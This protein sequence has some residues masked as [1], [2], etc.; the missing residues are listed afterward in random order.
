[1]DENSHLKRARRVLPLKRRTATALSG[2]FT[3]AAG[4]A[5]AAGAFLWTPFSEGILYPSTNGPVRSAG[6]EDG[7]LNL[8]IFRH[9]PVFADEAEVVTHSFKVFNRSKRPLRITDVQKSCSCTSATLTAFEIA[10]RKTEALNM[11]ADIAGRDGAFATECILRTFQN[12]LRMV[13]RQARC[14]KPSNSSG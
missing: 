14:T 5:F 12:P 13:Y 10:P 11:S 7:D 4:L 9:P 3:V 8:H 6:R 2:V 1:V